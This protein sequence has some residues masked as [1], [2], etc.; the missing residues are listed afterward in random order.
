MKQTIP[1]HL[2]ELRMRLIYFFLFFIVF[3]VVV[4]LFS[5]Y[6]VSWL[7]D[8]V[9]DV[10]RVNIINLSMIEYFVA[11]IKI[12]FIL[13]FVPSLPILAY[14]IAEYVK[15]ALTGR[16]RRFFRHL[17]VY[18]PFSIL[19]FLVSVVFFYF[20]FYKVILPFVYSMSL[21]AS[22]YNYW[23]ISKLIDTLLLFFLPVA[24]GFQLP[25]ISTFLFKAGFISKEFLSRKRRFFYVLVFILAS[26]FT[27][28]DVVSQLIVAFPLIVLFEVSNLILKIMPERKG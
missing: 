9:L 12:S 17:W 3:F 10:V 2:L 15:P 13:V 22:I 6:L 23:S 28:P 18:M 24:I 26:V 4:Y 21:K 8:S 16:E 20:S 1:E 27:P 25:I 19:L 14:H 7:V 11:K 5:D